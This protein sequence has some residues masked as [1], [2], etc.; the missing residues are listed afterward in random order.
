MT[1]APLFGLSDQLVAITRTRRPASGSR[2]AGGWKIDGSTAFDDEL[3]IDELDPE[4][5]M[6][7]EAVPR[8]DDR[9]GRQLAR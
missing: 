2:S 8:L 5:A 1:S 4:R 9:R 7:V 3:R 6:R